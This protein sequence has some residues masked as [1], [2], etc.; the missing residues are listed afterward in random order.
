M[1]LPGKWSREGLPLYCEDQIRSQTGENLA[2]FLSSNLC[3]RNQIMDAP[4]SLF[5]P[6]TFSGT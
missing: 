4:G 5:S 2:Q 1:F 3:R 6:I